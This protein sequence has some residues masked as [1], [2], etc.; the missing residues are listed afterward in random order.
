LLSIGREQ[1]VKEALYLF[2]LQKREENELSQAFT[3]YNTRIITPP[4]GSLGPTEPRKSFILLIALI[5]GLLIPFIAVITKERMDT[6]VRGRKDLENSTLPF[7]GEIPLYQPQ[8]RNRRFWKKQ[9]EIEAIVV[10]EG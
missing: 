4:Y 1:K 5:T 9:P 8:K 2:L 7:L 6:T 10:E 3:A